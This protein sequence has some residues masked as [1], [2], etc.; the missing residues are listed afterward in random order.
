MLAKAAMHARRVAR[1][2]LGRHCVAL[3]TAPPTSSTH[4]SKPRE[5]GSSRGGLRL[6]CSHAAF[7]H[8]WQWAGTALT[9]AAGGLHEVI[10]PPHPDFKTR[11]PLP[12]SRKL[13]W[14]W[15]ALRGASTAPRATPRP[16]TC[17]AAPRHGPSCFAL[18]RN[19]WALI[20]AGAPASSAL[21]AACV[22][23][24]WTAAWEAA[25]GPIRSCIVT[26]TAGG[27]PSCWLAGQPPSRRCHQVRALRP[28]GALRQGQR[29]PVLVSLSA[30][31]G[32][33]TVQS[34]ACGGP[35]RAVC[36]PHLPDSEYSFWASTLRAQHK[37]RL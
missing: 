26:G 18:A 17:G 36:L 37:G 25:A 19:Y 14:T 34:A 8:A 32:P 31:L 21:P 5:G 29:G 13:A 30:S 7:P 15:T 12:P 9:A 28:G 27:R 24:G 10:E 4:A 1:S 20:C 22:P 3:H 16:A 6:P 23:G 2:A 35:D 33:C 11:G